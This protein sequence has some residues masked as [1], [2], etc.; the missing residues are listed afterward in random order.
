MYTLQGAHTTLANMKPWVW[1]VKPEEPANNNNTP[2]NNTGFNW[3][4]TST[5]P[6]TKVLNTSTRVV[7][8]KVHT[9]T[10][11][12]VKKKD[13]KGAGYY[14]CVAGNL[15]GYLV[16]C[17][18]AVPRRLVGRGGG[19]G[20]QETRDG[21]NGER[22]RERGWCCC[23]WWFCCG[24]GSWRPPSWSP[25]AQLL[26][27]P[28]CL[29]PTLTFL[30]PSFRPPPLASHQS[31]SS[32]LSHVAASRAREALKK[33]FAVIWSV[34]VLKSSALEVVVTTSTFSVS[35]D[36]E[37][38]HLE[39]SIRCSGIIVGSCGFLADCPM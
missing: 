22:E 26:L 35:Q 31:V 28:T 12:W 30:C 11:T 1:H 34:Y 32:H 3:S 15:A 17:E 8:E 25:T 10:T 38:I 27:H 23:F 20:R 13:S 33:L 21:R 2:P 7:C 5:R 29:S 6:S 9:G 16:V 37:C 39:I 36:S 19:H 18:R 14:C 24:H 4:N